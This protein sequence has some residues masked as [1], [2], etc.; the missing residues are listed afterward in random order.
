RAPGVGLH[1]PQAS[2]AAALAADPHDDVADLARRAA[3]RPRAA[4][5]HD[6]AADARAPE[7]AE[8]RAVRAPGAERE[9]GVGRDLDVVAEQRAGAERVLEGRA[10]RELALPVRQVAGARH[11]ARGR[12]DVAR[13]ADAH[14][15]E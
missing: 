5:E 10:E 6:P 14:A 13:R 7:D 12:V 15:P 1:A 4:V 3:P 11:R 9:L 2:A 8:D